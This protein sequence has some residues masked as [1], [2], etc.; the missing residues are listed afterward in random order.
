MEQ[1]IKIVDR[2][3]DEPFVW[4]L[5]TEMA[6]EVWHNGLFDLYILYDDESESQIHAYE[7][8][9]RALENGC[10]IGIEVGHIPPLKQK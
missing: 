5:V 4:L 8:L 7:D 3:T 6:K 2:D 10:D 9:T 1:P